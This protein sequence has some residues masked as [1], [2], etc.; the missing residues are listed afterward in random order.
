[1]N[2]ISPRITVMLIILI[3]SLL[4]MILAA[5]IGLGVDESYVVSIARTLSLSYFDHPPLHFWIVWLTAHLTNTEIG[6]VLRFPFIV[7]FAATTWMMYR[8][9]TR[10]FS[11]WAGVYAA[12]ILNVSAVFSLS[13]G[14]WILPDGPVFYDGSHFSAGTIVFSASSKTFMVVMGRRR[15]LNWARN[16]GQISCHFLS[17]W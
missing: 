1:M 15:L 12:L 9:G 3:S 2:A 14:S 16:V 17:C 10:L 11:E 5:S 13:T 4:R 6:I 8:L 7:L